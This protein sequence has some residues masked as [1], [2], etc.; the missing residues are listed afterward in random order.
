MRLVSTRAPESRSSF[1][2]AI[3]A[4]RAP[5]LGLFVPETIPCFRDVEALLDQPIL[6]KSLP[7]TAA[8]LRA[9]LLG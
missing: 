2:Q 4:G 1:A 8:A 6:P 3:Q 5:G 7:A 9:E